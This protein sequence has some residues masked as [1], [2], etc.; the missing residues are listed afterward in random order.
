MHAPGG[1]GSGRG[2]AVA[3]AGG[4]LEERLAHLGPAGVVEADEERMGHREDDTTMT[5]HVIAALPSRR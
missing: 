3:P 5:P 1:L 2:G 4:L